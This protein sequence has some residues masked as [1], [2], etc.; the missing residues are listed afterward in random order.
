MKQAKPGA[1]KAKRAVWAVGQTLI[2]T[3]RKRRQYRLYWRLLLG[4]TSLAVLFRAE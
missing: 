4:Q 3:L 1:L 2:R